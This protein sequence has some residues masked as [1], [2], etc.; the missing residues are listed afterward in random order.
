MVPY[1]TNTSRSATEHSV[2]SGLIFITSN[3]D[4]VDQLRTYLDYP[5]AHQAIELT[6]IQSLSLE[7]VVRHKAQEAYNKLKRPVIVD[8]TA[9]IFSALDRLPGP[10][11]KYFLTELKPEGI[12]RLIDGY[13]DRSAIGAVGIAYCDGVHTEFFS[14]EVI[15]TVAQT[16]KGA[17]G[18]GWDKLFIPDGFTQTR[19][20]MSED[21]YAKTS[22]RK[23]ALEKLATYLRSE[24][25][26]TS[27]D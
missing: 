3:P 26:N 9:V 18:F 5:V 1:K 19:A 6:E 14:G 7:E 27:K 25:D 2:P 21:D 15:G 11:I 23:I 20:E 13:D 8:D 22:A 4:K 16:P 12:C 17:G 10:F 24:I